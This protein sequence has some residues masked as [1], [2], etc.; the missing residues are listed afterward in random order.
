[1]IHSSNTKVVAS[2]DAGTTASSGTA[3]LT[4]DRLD[5]DHASIVVARAANAST[6]FASVLKVAESDDNSSYSDITAFVGGGTGG[7]TIPTVTST[8][9]VSLV[10][11]DVDCRARKRYLKV[12]VTPSTAVNVAI[13]ARLSRGHVFPATAADAGLIGSVSG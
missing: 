9:S 10:R 5:Y 7:F 13:E 6:T 12:S 1:M 3:T 2:L 11:L 4:I 8:G